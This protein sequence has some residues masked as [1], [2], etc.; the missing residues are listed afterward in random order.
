[1]ITRRKF[2]AGASIAPVVLA[3]ASIAPARAMAA[4]KTFQMATSTPAKIVILGAGFSGLAAAY[5]LSKQGTDATILEARPRIGGRVLS[6]TID[7]ADNLVVELGAEWVGASHARLLSLCKELGLELKNNQLN[8]R[9]IY[10]GK[11]FEK[12]AWAYSDAWKNKFQEILDNYANLSE[13]DKIDLDQMDWWRYL[14]DNGI[15]GQDLDVRELIDSTDFGESI[16]QVSAFAALSEYAESSRKNEMD[17]KIVGGNQQLA[18]AIA[19]KLKPEQILLNHRV[20]SI[21]QSGETVTITCSNGF[22]I[23]ANKVICTL[24]TFA[25]KQIAWEPMLPRD[26]QRAIS[27]LQYARINKN[28]LLYN[29]RF[30]NDESY[31]LVTDVLPHYLYHAT[32]NQPSQKGVLISYVIGDKADVFARQSDEWRSAVVDDAL[33]SAFIDTRSRLLKQVS[34][35]WGNDDYSRGSYAIY[36]TGQWFTIRPILERNFEN[37]YFAGEHI[38]DWQGFMEGAIETGEAAAEQILS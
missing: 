21:V 27:G 6:H 17:Y 8:T 24:P 22:K 37:V 34:Y 35:Y 18:K 30:W 9:L 3:G 29:Q 33:K 13:E 4:S 10:N 25:M 5:F 11:Y 14:V 31:D 26:K 2:L 19:A 7:D 15:S 36:G 38:A 20:V 23:E 12:E 1:M 32:K 28:A 16:R